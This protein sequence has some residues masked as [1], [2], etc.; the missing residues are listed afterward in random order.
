MILTIDIGNTSVNFGIFE[1]RELILRYS[2]PSSERTTAKKCWTKTQS[3]ITPEMKIDGAICCSVV[4]VRTE[5]IESFV[6]KFLKVPFK[7]LKKGDDLGIINKYSIPE[8]VGWDRLINALAVKEFYTLPAIIADLGTA[9][10]IDVVNAEYEY[11]GGIIAPGLGI[12][13][14]A[15]HKKTSLLPRVELVIPPEI[16]GKDTVSSMQSGLTYGFALMIKGLVDGLKEELNLND[17]TVIATGGYTR[18][19]EPLLDDFADVIDD[20]LTL[21]GLNLAY[22]LI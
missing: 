4:P 19:L 10:T 13:V 22:E 1:K 20:N 12:S 5:M 7:K 14:E 17:A 3:F 11:L 21:K 16:L 18:I 2:L 15:L 8:Q 9:V 6:D